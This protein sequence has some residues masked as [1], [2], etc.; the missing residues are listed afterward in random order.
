MLSAIIR[1][2]VRNKLIIGLL[3]IAWIV[4]G[5]VNLM[6]LPIDAVPDITNNQVMVITTSPSLSAP[7]VER[8]ITVPIEQATRNIPGIVEQRSFSRSG[9]SLVTI[10]FSDHTD[11]YW[12]RQQVSERLAQ[13]RTQIPPGMGSPELGPVTTGL[14]EIYQYVVRPLPGYEG[15][16][17]LTD[18]RDIQDWIVRRQLLGT[19]G[20]ADVSSFGGYLKQYEVAI[21][22]QR[23]KVYGLTITDVFDALTKNNQNAGGAYIARGPN[24]WFIR[25]E[26]LTRN[27]SDI[28]QI[29]IKRVNG[30]PVLVGDVA[31]VHIGHAIRYGAMVYTNR[32]TQQEVA[33]AVLMMIKGGNSNQVIKAVKQRIEEI[34]KTLPEGV[35]IEPFLDRTKMVNNA[36]H[37]V[38][39]NLTE[40]AL[41]V[42]FILVL[43]LA[44][45]RAGLIVASVIPLSMLFAI[46][47][48]NLFGVSGNLMSLGALDFGLLV[49]GGVIIIEA[50]M[51]KLRHAESF[52]G[53]TVL[54]QLE[55]DHV[56]TESAEK[57]MNAAAFG[58]F[59][60]LIVYLPI[61]SLQG[62][63]GKM[64]RPMAETVAFAVL[65]AFILSITYV[66]MISSLL[67][68]KKISGRINYADKALYALQKHYKKA[69]VWTLR[70]WKIV[71][72]TAL[73]LF[74]ICIWIF[75]R[76]GGVFIPQLE[77]GD[78][79]VNTRLLTGASLTNT[80]QTTSQAAKLLVDSFPEV[81]KVVVKIG[82]G[83][84][85]TDPMPIE[86]SDMM[87]ILKDKSQWSSAHS[88]PELADKMSKALQVIPG[89]ATGFQFPVQ[90]RFNELMTG[91]RQDVVCKIFGDDLDTLTRYAHQLGN[92]IQTISGARDL[93][94]E[95]VTGIPQIVVQYNRNALAQYGLNV[96]DVNQIIQSGYAG[97]VAGSVYEEDRRYDLVV[98]LSQTE[99]NDLATL[100]QLPVSLPGG[101]Q[102]P[103]K[104]LAH[105]QMIDGPYQIQREDGHRRIIVGFNVR[106]RDVESIVNELQQKVARELHLPAGYYI[107]YGGEYENLKRATSRLSI[108]VP[109]AL[110]LILL[111]LY[112]AFHQ[113]KYGIMIFSAIPLSAIGGI[114]SLWLRGMPFSIS[115]GVGF[116]A[117][118]G[119]A[120][121]NGI[122]LISEMN[123][124][125]Q[126][127][128]WSIPRII[129][130]ATRVRLRPV[131]MTAS[132]ASLGF[133]P[134]AL[135]Q[136]AGAE[137]QRPL[138]TVVIG[139]L[140]S[141]TFLTLFILPCLYMLIESRPIR[142]HGAKKTLLLALLVI[143]GIHAKGQ[144]SPYQLSLSWQEVKTRLASTDPRWQQAQ[145]EIAW[146]KAMQ[147]TAF[148]L[149]KTS[150][151]GEYGQIN[152][153]T[154]DT[155]F[156]IQQNFSLPG[157]YLRV[158]EW[159]KQQVEVANIQA[160]LKRASILNM[161][162]A[163]YIELQYQQEKL[164]LLSTLDSMYAK[165]SQIANLRLQKGETNVL[166]KNAIVQE[167]IHV[168]TLYAAAM[169][170]LHSAQQQM[171]QWLQTD[172][173]IWAKD[174]LSY[175]NLQI[176]TSQLNETPFL[177]YQAQQYAISEKAVRVEKARLW[178]EFSIGYSNQSIVGWQ[179]D[180][181]RNEQ[182]FGP[183]SRFSSLMASVYFP[184][185]LQPFRARIHAAEVQ[186][187]IQQKSLIWANQYFHM[188]L[189]KLTHDLKKYITQIQTYQQNLL[190]L[191][192]K[193]LEAANAQ[194]TQ[195][196]IGY[197]EWLLTMR[198]ASET[199][200]QYL[201]LLH[202]QQLT[203]NEIH[204]LLTN[205]N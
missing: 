45:L 18:L 128:S 64:F 126:A 132:V 25:A 181:N 7:D 146:A 36:I 4:W 75:S 112:F 120:V 99:R 79:A 72:T 13:V 118:F 83:E 28:R 119:V 124:V 80:I 196:E 179:T 201:Q 166:E 12:A 142:K 117:L 67:L 114:L 51:H 27:L 95:T 8:F 52:P 139:G 55:M 153:P 152:S 184:L 37:T 32:H 35:T 129:L 202:D 68:E 188:Q 15:K 94:V 169:A 62:I 77:E 163:L 46:I 90:M 5:T 154:N 175:I 164:K 182:Y 69:L 123:R 71:L 174:S 49:D 17:S 172:S 65:G 3:L 157:Y 148:D 145:L 87:V 105:I 21:N 42:I 107:T 6:K 151:A 198:Q 53:K 156:T 187:E 22:P 185:F 91:A 16:Y 73:I 195:G 78:F 23:L 31:D 138:A 60:I 149:P 111:L 97:A 161:A 2:S 122:V 125:K 57:M 192:H 136:S 63:E 66:P 200:L 96:Q 30:V 160:Q 167:A 61:L 115:A 24:A 47:M 29:E 11:I 137:V 56:V 162:H 133:L 89:I 1:F 108:A 59:I 74:A 204:L 121:L 135:S 20:V 48:M 41:I 127:H 44:N 158:K 134:M 81:Q 178:P 190:P 109:I 104:L 177:Q 86:A 39:K 194:Y 58:Q 50:I 144:S 189:S 155:R 98:R 170:D 101:Q 92:I 183:S 19:P 76:L 38:E 84:I 130:Y 171:M 54:D 193:S 26:G 199:E 197:V 100:A 147:K 186:A 33:G 203:I 140:I 14:G 40:G 102:I 150:I 85:P 191:S 180:K 106:G 9:L 168:Q 131:L 70:R 176:D 173:L 165:A 205:I 93:Y 43:F 34:K 141:A 113:I 103:L 88:F 143:A 10:V 116:I 82:S 159:Y 110:L